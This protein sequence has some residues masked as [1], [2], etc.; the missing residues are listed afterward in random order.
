MICKCIKIKYFQKSGNVKIRINADKPEE[1]TVKL[2]IPSWSENTQF[3]L[4][5]GN[6]QSPPA[7]Q[8]AEIKRKWQSGDEISLTLDM[9]C[10]LIDAPKGGSTLDSDRYRALRSGPLVLCRN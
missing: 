8:Y 6:M 7:G 10:R 1:F 3:R 9:R 4:A 5:D 2:R